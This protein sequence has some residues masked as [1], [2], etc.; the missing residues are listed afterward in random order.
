MPLTVRRATSADA[1]VVAEFNRRLAE[2]TEGKTLDP[3]VLAA[4]VAAGLT[5]PV[6]ALY[7]VAEED[8]RVLGQAMVTFEWSDWRN[9]WIW[10]IQSV[11]V[12]AE[13]RRQGVFRS[14]YQHIHQIAHRDPAVIAL[15]LY[16]E[17]NNHSAQH[18]YG[19]IGMKPTGYLVYE[20]YPL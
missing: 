18:T 13:A 1:A 10:W 2:E 12:R 8:G 19:S 17:Q 7:F 4:G 9:G 11:Y 15:R 20:K 6:R 14:L 5:D 3:G 16:V